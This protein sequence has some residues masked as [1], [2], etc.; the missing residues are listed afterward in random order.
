MV[1]LLLWFALTQGVTEFLPV[2]S[3]GHLELLG[4]GLGWPG[5]PLLLIA[6]LHLATAAA[7]LVHFRRIYWRTALGLWRGGPERA[8]ALR[9]GLAQGVTATVGAALLLALGQAGVQRWW[10]SAWLVGV[11]ELLNA[12]VLWTAPRGV[13]AGSGGGLADL[14]DLSWRQAALVGLAQGV[15]A[16]PGL[17]RQGLTVAAA[18]HLGVGRRE[19]AEL[20]LLLAPPVMLAA[21]AMWSAQ[22]WPEP[23]SWTV[24]WPWRAAW[25]SPIVLGVTAAAALAALRW[26]VSWVRAGRLHWFA[27]WSA[28]LGAATLILAGA[29][30]W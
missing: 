4:L 30:W 7:A 21:T 18:L 13:P 6:W 9:Y 28:G 11:M 24:S 27:P 26:M 3:S 17:S 20:S 23:L 12:A 8:F 16:V 14:A 10:L 5:E 25:E 29:G 19:S 22:S 1:R 2:S 15:A